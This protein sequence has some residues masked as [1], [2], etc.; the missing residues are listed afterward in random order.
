MGNARKILIIDDDDELRD[1]LSEQLSLHE[2]FD[3]LLAANASGEVGILLAALDATTK[4]GFAQIFG[5]NTTASVDAVASAG[6]PLYID[7]TAGRADAGTDVSG[8]FIIG[9][10][11]TSAAS[12]N[13]ASVFLNYPVVTNVA[14]D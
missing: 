13:V 6:L 12:S 1:S 5:E 8:D 9:A 14:I 2:E 10:I 3:T 11:S 4:Y 7:G